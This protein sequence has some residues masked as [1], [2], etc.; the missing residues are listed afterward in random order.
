VWAN[1]PC[2]GLRRP[3][4]A[5]GGPLPSLRT[6]AKRRTSIVGKSA[7]AINCPIRFAYEFGVFTASQKNSKSVDIELEE[8][9]ARDGL[10]VTPCRFEAPGTRS[11]GRCRRHQ[12]LCRG[13]RIHRVCTHH[14]SAAIDLHPHRD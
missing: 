12:P 2:A 5:S 8:R 9:L 6:H 14:S 7:S 10:L 13:P 11:F 3:E 4:K 1:C